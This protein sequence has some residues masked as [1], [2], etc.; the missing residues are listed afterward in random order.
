M[1]GC[2]PLISKLL[3]SEEIFHP[4]ALAFSERRLLSP[5]RSLYALPLFL[6]TVHV[7]GI[8]EPILQTG[9]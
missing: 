6:F 9:S 7:V 3:V 4:R 5:V 2:R 1:A 8:N